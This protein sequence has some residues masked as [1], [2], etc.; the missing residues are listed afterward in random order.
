MTRVA[1]LGAGAHAREIAEILRANGTSAIGFVDEDP[2]LHQQT[3]DGLPVLGDWS[4]LTCVDASE[5][6]VIC[7]SGFSDQRKKMTARAQ[8][9]GLKF[10]SAI[11]PLAYVSPQ[12]QLGAGAVIYPYAVVCRGSAIGGH[13]VINSGAIVSHDAKIG[14]HV[15]INPGVNIA[16]NV[17]VG[18]GC[19]LG[20]GCNII[21][22]IRIGDGTTVGAGA[23]VI[24][25]L[26][27]NV[28]A[29]G[30]PAVII[31]HNLSQHE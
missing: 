10:V 24:R 19:Y 28:T 7:G 15:T 11:S 4:W 8:E 21:Q 18:D 14:S 9:I 31:K 22:G 26:P 27:E 6:K 12:T 2:R 17:T 3:I 1:I 30:V 29:V 23:A 25:D 13:V 16:G 5:V 20:I